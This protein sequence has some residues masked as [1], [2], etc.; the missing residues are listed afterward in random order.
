MSL[1]GKHY[2]GMLSMADHLKESSYFPNKST[3]QIKHVLWTD[4][5]KDELFGKNMQHYGWRKK[6]N[7]RTSSQLLSPVEE[8]S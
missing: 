8:P 3:C 5:T 7:M 1:Y 2:T 4:E 6:G